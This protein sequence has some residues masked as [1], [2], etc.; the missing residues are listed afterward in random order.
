MHQTAQAGAHRRLVG[1]RP[2]HLGDTAAR[3]RAGGFGEDRDQREHMAPADRERLVAGAD[4]RMP[5][6]AKLHLV[7][8]DAGGR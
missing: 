3:Q 1:F 2:Q 5:E 6:Q 8:P 7:H 4:L